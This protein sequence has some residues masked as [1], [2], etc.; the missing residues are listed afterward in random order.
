MSRTRQKIKN[1]TLHVEQIKGKE[2]SHEFEENPQVFPII[3][4]MIKNRQCEFLKPFNIYLKAFSVREIIEVQG[5]LKTRAR[6]SCSR[7]LK[8][9]DT[10]LA[11]DFELSY[12]KE[13]PGL[14]DVFDEQEIELKVEE[15]GMFYFKGEEINLQQGIQEQVV[16][17][18]PLQPLCDENCKGL[19]PRCGSD[20]NQGDCGCKNELSANKFAVLKNLK[21]DKP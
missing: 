8:N 14:M 17:A 6:L 11:S 1:L 19:C 3:A 20:L 16:M 5:T 15:I 10:P 2:F 9:F 21:L 7:C 4:E 12:T 18:L 13:I